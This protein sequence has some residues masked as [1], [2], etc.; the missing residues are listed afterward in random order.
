MADALPNPQRLTELRAKIDAVDESMHALLMQRAGVIDELIRI[1]GADQAKGAAFRPGREAQ[2]MRVLAERHSGSV[3]LSMI[4]HV[5]REIISTFTWLQAP[6]RVHLV[7]GA[8]PATMRDMARFQFGF[9]V[10]MEEHEDAAGAMDAAMAERN[11]LVIVPLEGAGAWWDG[12]DS[13]GGLSVMARLPAA[14]VPFPTVDSFVLSP[15]LSDPVPFDLRLY[16]GLL[17]SVDSLDR[18]TGGEVIGHGS[19]GQRCLIAIPAGGSAPHDLLD[20]R[21]AGGYFAPA[22]A[23]DSSA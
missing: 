9:T 22:Q 16:T 13:S 5:W 21:A 23:M 6:Y 17:K 15:P 11:A 3:P 14:D 19:E 12:L 7:G 8:E 20:I 4:V 1:K 18:W 2:M 10:A